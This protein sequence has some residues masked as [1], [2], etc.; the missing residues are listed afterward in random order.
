MAS[1]SIGR[2]WK[3]FFSAQC[4]QTACC[5]ALWESSHDCTPYG[6]SCWTSHR[7]TPHYLRECGCTFVSSF[8]KRKGVQSP[9]LNESPTL[10]HPHPS[11]FKENQTTW[12]VGAAPVHWPS[13]P[14]YNNSYQLY[15]P[16]KKLSLIGSKMG[17][18]RQGEQVEALMKVCTT[19]SRV[20]CRTQKHTSPHILILF[21]SNRWGH[22]ESLETNVSENGI[23]KKSFKIHL[24]C[25]AS[26]WLTRRGSPFEQVIDFWT[27]QSTKLILSP[28]SPP[29]TLSY[30]PLPH[31]YK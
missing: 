6:E 21:F 14:F 11:F 8:R 20:R 13:P 15:L 24:P 19:K 12:I 30:F 22:E 3:L 2:E 9:P 16:G 29:E 10:S 28:E 4:F 1:T 23:W 27:R 25:K 7:C 5:N 17:N 31:N 26:Q 18:K